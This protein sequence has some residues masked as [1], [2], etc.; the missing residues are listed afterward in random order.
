MKKTY[1]SVPVR[2]LRAFG[3][4]LIL[5]LS[6]IPV[7]AVLT[8]SLTPYSKMLESLLFPKYL[9]LSNYVDAFKIVYRQ[10]GNS[11]KYSLTTVVLVLSISIPS[12]YVIARF[13][14]K[15]RKLLMFGLLFTQMLAGIVL[16]PAIYT[17]FSRL[18][19]NN[20][21]PALIFIYV[22]VNLSLSVWLLISFFA[23]I[24]REVEEAAIIDGV[25]RLAMIYQVAVPMVKPG[26]AV[27]A[28]FIFIN[29]YNEFVIPLFLVTDTASQTIT[30]VLNSLMS[31]TTIEW[32]ILAAGAV[33]GMI[34]PL[35]AFLFFQKSIVEGASAGAVKG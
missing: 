32:H 4:L 27:S 2:I 26:I 3:A 13:K 33:V 31:A 34:P 1:Y 16:I 12:A 17:I 19:L 15:A 6:F 30:Q 5:G 20:S 29:V 25:G 35:V 28:I 8:V 11:F 21:V 24:P 14:F 10:M 7:Y 18:G 9:E 22:G 23:A